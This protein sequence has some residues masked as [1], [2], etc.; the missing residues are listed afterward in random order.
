MQ[1][2]DVNMLR[3]YFDDYLAFHNDPLFLGYWYHGFRLGALAGIT[4][5]E[6]HL[7]TPIPYFDIK[8]NHVRPPK[9][10]CINQASACSSFVFTVCR[11][12]EDRR[13]R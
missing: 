12:A 4:A 2:S 9:K 5:D 13:K 3:K 8:H 6:I 10:R 11:Q 1:K 7:D